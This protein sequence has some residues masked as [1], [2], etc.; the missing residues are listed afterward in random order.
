MIFMSLLEEL[1]IKM[2]SLSY[3]ECPGIGDLL[4]RSDF[5]QRSVQIRGIHRVITVHPVGSALHNTRSVC[6][7]NVHIGSDV[8][9]SFV[10][11]V[12]SLL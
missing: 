2:D 1:H 11:Q 12:R 9:S 7:T 6:Q 8:N 3:F 4:Q 5:M 10:F